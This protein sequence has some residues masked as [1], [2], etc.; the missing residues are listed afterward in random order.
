[1]HTRTQ[2]LFACSKPSAVFVYCRASG[3][4]MLPLSVS[5]PNLV[6]Q[7]NASS[8]TTLHVVQVDHVRYEI[9]SAVPPDPDVARL[10]QRYADSLGAQIDRRLGSTAADLEGRF[11]VMRTR[12]T[13]LGNLVADIMLF[14]LNTDPNVVVHCTFFNSGAYAELPNAMTCTLPTSISCSLWSCHQLCQQIVDSFL[15]ITAVSWAD[16]CHLPQGR[17]MT[18][19]LWRPRPQSATQA[20]P[21]ACRQHPQRPRA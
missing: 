18:T 2:R 3:F 16:A 12:E 14:W 11:S 5:C 21:Y 8:A 1:M 19:S 9:T 17:C 4:C 6:S 13:N 20:F 10:V 7:K 15:V